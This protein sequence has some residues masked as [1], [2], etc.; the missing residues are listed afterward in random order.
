MC[1]CLTSRKLSNIKF[2]N[3]NSHFSTCPRASAVDI[4]DFKGTTSPSELFMWVMSNS[5]VNSNFAIPS[6]HFFK[7]GWTLKYVNHF[8]PLNK[9]FSK[10]F[11]L[12]RNPCTFRFNNDSNQKSRKLMILIK[13]VMLHYSI[14]Q[15]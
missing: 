12:Q 9:I 3:S 13:F 5:S 15:P 1:S 11:N 4:V 7:C 10:I 8:K 14:F 2:C 6:K